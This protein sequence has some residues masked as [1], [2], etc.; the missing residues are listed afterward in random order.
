M[1]PRGYNTRRLSPRPKKAEQTKEWYTKLDG[2]ED[3]T[4][5]SLEISPGALLFSLNYEADVQGGY[6]KCGF[7]ERFDG[8]AKPSDA[9]YHTLGFDQGSAAFSEG[10]IV[11]GATSGATGEVMDIQVLNF[12]EGY[13]EIFTGETI[14][15]ET[16]T[17]TAE[18]TAVFVTS[19][20]W[21]TLDAAGIIYLK[22]PSGAF[23]DNESIST[24]GGGRV[25]ANGTQSGVTLESGTYL[26]GDAAGTLYLCK[27]SG[28]FQ[29]DENLQVS[30]VTRAVANGTNY[31]NGASEDK[32]SRAALL[33]ATSNVRSDIG[34]ITGSGVIRG[35]MSLNGTLYAMRDNAGG[36]AKDLWKSTSSGW[37]QVTLPYYLN[38]D[39]GSVAFAEGD[40]VTGATSGATGVVDAIMITSGTTGGGNQVGRLYLSSITGTFQ[41]NEALQVSA[42]PYALADGTQAQV[43]IPAGGRGESVVHNFGG[44]PSSKKIYGVDGVGEAFEFDGTDFY[45]IPSPLP[46]DQPNHCVIHKTYFFLSYGGSVIHSG[47]GDPRDWTAISGAVEIATG[48]SVV[49]FS[50]N[51][52]DI[53]T[54][55]NRNQT[56]LLYG[57]VATEWELKLHSEDSGAIEWSIQ[58]TNRP[59]YLDDQGLMSLTA[60]NAY[61]DFRESSISKPVDPLF[62]ANKSTVQSSLRV[63]TKN[64]YRIFFSNGTGIHARIDRK[65]PAFTRVNYGKVPYVTLST[66]DSNGDELLFFGSDDGYVYQLDVGRS[67]DGSPVEGYIRINY[68]H[69]DSPRIYKR[70][71]EAILQLKAETGAI[72]SFS[73]EYDYGG[74]DIEKGRSALFDILSGGGFWDIS[75]WGGFTWSSQTVGEAVAYLEGSGVNISLL[76]YSKS[77]SELPHTL[78]SILVKYAMRGPKR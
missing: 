63:K 71:I 76:V 52:G 39:T 48:D 16:S 62:R 31:K 70:F 23:L 3:L 35:L 2:G 77:S 41:N 15:G 4:T 38:F 74:G 24:G 51:P 60:V 55:H 72:I 56:Y 28:T 36:T 64:Q 13:Q 61:G 11:T 47:L 20:S 8:Q 26:G 9:V 12:D 29:D 40:T 27:V 17:E 33:H 32:L 5:P 75:T 68:W 59:I 18:V 14:T 66:D 37:T 7:Y 65:T 34:A 58:T 44:Q 10:D 54:I 42:T 19:G 21:R 50:K 53:L 46:T 69:M 30:A 78:E 6:S 73:S 57:A 67:A 1:L 45:H 22:S 49:G 43:V 25:V